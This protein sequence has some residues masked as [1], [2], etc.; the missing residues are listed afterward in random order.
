MT[1]YETLFDAV[2]DY[3][4]EILGAEAHIWAHPET[5]FREWNTHA[6]LKEKLC[7]MGYTV[8][9]AGDIP[10]FYADWDTGKPGPKVAVFAEMDALRIPEH[11]DADKESGAV[12]ACAHHCQCAA[13]LGV[14]HA[15]ASTDIKEHLCGSVRLFA[16]PAEELIE[17]DDRRELME[18]GVLHFYGGKQEFLYRGYLDGCDLAMMIHTGGHGLLLGI[19]CDGSICKRFTFLGKASHAA[20]PAQGINAFYAAT[21]AIG[22]VNALREQF[23]ED[24]LFR[25]SPIMTKCGDSDNNIPSEVTV[26]GL[27]RCSTVEK[28]Q[29]ANEKINRAFAASAAAI[30]CKLKIEDKIGYSPRVE[31]KNFQKAF[32]D[33]GRMLFPEEEVR[34]T[35]PFSPGCTDMGDVSLLLPSVHAF[36]GCST[37]PGH[38]AAFYVEDPYTA[39]VTNAKVQVGVLCR[40]LENGAAFAK[41][42]LAERHTK[43]STL[44]EYLQYTKALSYT[45]EAV[46]YADDGS[47]IL[48]YKA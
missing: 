17:L 39:T 18:K 32:L 7:A 1:P 31:D 48:K 19:G 3:R 40:L 12:H 25:F 37:L 43:F 38:T 26:R 22:A 27:L 10:G 15:L 5:G 29:A 30:G 2:E 46:T 41:E 23:G 8:T 21:S 11:P 28:L 4:E 14:A 20:S 36:I 34:G 6:Y 47:V 9:E 16:V 13:M 45:G 33:V 35:K 42:V 24:G 44:D